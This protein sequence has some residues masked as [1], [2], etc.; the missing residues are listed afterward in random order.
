MNARA[1]VSVVALSVLLNVACGTRASPERS[2][3]AT[4]EPYGTLRGDLVSDVPG[5]AAIDVVPGAP[6]VSGPISVEVVRRIIRRHLAELQRCHASARE[7]GVAVGERVTLTFVIGATGVV[8]EAST[9]GLGDAPTEAC[10]AGAMR[11]WTFPAPLGGGIVRVVYPLTLK[12]PTTAPAAG[13]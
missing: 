3:P 6:T 5:F 1:A 7:R 10:F 13:R 12:P 8:T 4:G 11:R 2:V 9:S